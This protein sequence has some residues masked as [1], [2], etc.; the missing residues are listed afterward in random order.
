M[1]AV[2]NE[3]EE[4]VFIELFLFAFPVLESLLIV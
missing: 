4:D 1:Y 2:R 3:P